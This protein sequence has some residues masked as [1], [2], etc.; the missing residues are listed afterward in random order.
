[1]KCNKAKVSKFDPLNDTISSLELVD[2]LG[3]DQTIVKSARISFAQDS[4]D[5][6][7]KRNIKLIEYLL[8]NNHWSV[9]EHCFVT[10]RVTLPLPICVQWLRH[11]SWNFN[12]QSRRYSSEELKTYLPKWRKQSESNKQ[13]SSE[14][15]DEPGIINL[16]DCLA[17][18][19]Y[20]TCL[21]NYHQAIELG[22]AKEQARFLLPEGL[23]TSL[24]ATANLRS[25]MHWYQQRADN[26]AQWEI[27]V[28]ADCVSE[29]MKELFPI[30]WNIFL[31]RFNK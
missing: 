4:I 31:E 15:I 9:F 6:A 25:I 19:T 11:K 1:M 2:F 18:S 13:G 14:F 7:E 24:Y 8:T 22:A 17:I 30:S 29:I 23:Y 26:H 10:F 3:T 16:L 27:R 21:S 20:E 12:Q 5:F 28:Y